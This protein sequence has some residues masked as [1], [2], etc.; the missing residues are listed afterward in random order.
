MILSSWLNA[1]A[2]RR[3]RQQLKRL[4]INPSTIQLC[5]KFLL[6]GDGGH[7]LRAEQFQ[8]GMNVALRGRIVIGANGYCRMGDW[9]TLG[10]GTQISAMVGVDISAQ[11]IGAEGVF[12]SDNNNHPVSPR[13]RN[14]MT[15]RKLGTEMWK[16]NDQIASAPIH[17]ERGVWLGRYS[18]VLKGVTIGQ[19]SII[20][21]GAVVTKSIPPFSIAA[22]NPARVVGTIENDLE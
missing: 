11:V 8:I 21:A 18:T 6:K 9:A 1:V 19:W 10:L 3:S 14:E 13:F 2:N 16:M 20:G 17:I 7:E 15:Q 5:H 12:I 4:G 22:G